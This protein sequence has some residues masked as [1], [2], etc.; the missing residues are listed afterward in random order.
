M[1]ETPA[2]AAVLW[3]LMMPLQTQIGSGL[4]PSDA[5]ASI[6]GLAQTA[7]NVAQNTLASLQGG[8]VTT[9]FIFRLL[10]QLQF[11]ISSVTA[12]KAVAGLDA[13][14]TSLDYSGIMSADCTTT[15]SAAQVCVTWVSGNFPVD[16]GGWLLAYKLNAD[17]TRTPN[18]FTS[19]QTLGLQTDLQAFIAT[20]A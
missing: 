5:Y 17:G 10:D 8:P 16:V 11:F 20:I 19:A 6:R 4:S 18:S 12:W 2:G 13:Y 7:K 1:G 14:A 15:I 9:D 3:V